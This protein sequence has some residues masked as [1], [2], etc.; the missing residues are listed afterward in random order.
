MQ[1]SVKI[2]SININVIYVSTLNNKTD[3]VN[4]YEKHKHLI[5]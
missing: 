5:N 1:H 4:F 2:N 3:F